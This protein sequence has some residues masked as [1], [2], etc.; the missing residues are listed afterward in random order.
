M[1]VVRYALFTLLLGCCRCQ[2]LTGG[3][4]LLHVIDNRG[5]MRG[6][7]AQSSLLKGSV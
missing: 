5:M 4:T 1:G 3:N 6:R 2:L 7:I